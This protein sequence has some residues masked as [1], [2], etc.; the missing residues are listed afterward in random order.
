MTKPDYQQ[1]ALLLTDPNEISNRELAR[2]LCV[3]EAQIRKAKKYALEC[4]KDQQN[5]GLQLDEVRTILEDALSLKANA[6]GA[7]KAEIRRALDL[8]N[9]KSDLL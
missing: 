5:S 6:G 7:I 3:S 1:I 2:W 4:K 8:M 9:Y